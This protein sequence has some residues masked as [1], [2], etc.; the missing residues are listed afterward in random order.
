MT[1]KN[2][3]GFN[4]N[5]F[6]AEKYQVSLTQEEMNYIYNLAAKKCE[7]GDFENALP[8]FQ[9]LVLYKPS[10][11]LYQKS[12]AGCLQNLQ[13]YTEA[14][15][16][17]QTVYMLDSENNQDCLFYMAFCAI[18]MEKPDIAKNLLEEF[19]SQNPE[20]EH[21]K[22]ARLLLRGLEHEPAPES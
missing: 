4:L 3:R 14:Y 10:D 19:L 13:K 12:M 15:M 16:Q 17:Y 21:E 5:N 8:I 18:K 9:F 1:Q 6:I 7:I 20:H 11:M 2:E 22:K